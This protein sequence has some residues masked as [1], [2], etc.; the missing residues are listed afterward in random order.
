MKQLASQGDFCAS[1]VNCHCNL[2][3]QG[4]NNSVKFLRSHMTNGQSW[5]LKCC[6]YLFFLWTQ[7][8]QDNWLS[9][10]LGCSLLKRKGSFLLGAWYRLPKGWVTNSSC[11]WS[12]RQRAQEPTSKGRAELGLLQG[13]CRQGWYRTFVSSQNKCSTSLKE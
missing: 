8:Y 9:F 13:C 4:R 6:T 10:G 11:G 1:A 5:G 7:G 2:E 12:G 3:K